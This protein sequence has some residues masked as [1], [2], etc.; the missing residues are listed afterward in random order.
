MAFINTNPIGFDVRLREYREA[1]EKLHPQ[2][3]HSSHHN[4]L[5]TTPCS[6]CAASPAHS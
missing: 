5:E 3:L 4:A 2:P 6:D 1:Q